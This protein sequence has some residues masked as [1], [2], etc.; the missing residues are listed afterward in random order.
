[1]QSTTPD[2][3]VTASQST[4]QRLAVSSAKNRLASSRSSSLPSAKEE[5]LAPLQFPSGITDPAPAEE[6]EE[7]PWY[8]EP[9]TKM[10][11]GLE[12]LTKP[13]V[14][15]ND[16]FDKPWA[17][18]ML[19]AGQ[20]FV[21]GQQ[22]MEK[23]M[24]EKAPDESVW[25]TLRNAYENEDLDWWKKFM[26]ESTA[27]WWMV[28]P[29][30]LVTKAFSV[31]GKVL[32]KMPLA[33]QVLKAIVN[34]PMVKKLSTESLKSKAFNA[35][36]R[37][38]EVMTR[39]FRGYEASSPSDYNK[40]VT[41]LLTDISNRTVNKDVLQTLT[42]T[43]QK[44]TSGKHGAKILSHLDELLDEKTIGKEI[45]QILKAE[46]EV[47]ARGG[48]DNPLHDFQRVVEVIGG[49]ARNKYAK[50]AGVP[51]IEN[52]GLIG[53]AFK[54]WK[55][56]VL[57][58]PTYV[59]QN[60]VENFFRMMSES[61]EPYRFAGFETSMPLGKF[62]NP[63][64]KKMWVERTYKDLN[65]MMPEQFKQGAITAAAR[66]DGFD[67]A[68]QL[69]S[70]TQEELR[71]IAAAKVQYMNKP[72]VLKELTKRGD[73]YQKI[74]DNFPKD[75]SPF[76]KDIVNATATKSAM[77]GTLS[78][79]KE[80]PY[81][82][83]VHALT[84]KVTD[85]QDVF[86][87]GLY[88]L[89]YGTE[90]AEDIKI[91]RSF[92]KQDRSNRLAK[93]GTTPLLI[94]NHID[95]QATTMVWGNKYNSYIKAH[96]NVE[97][98]KLVHAVLD[99]DDVKGL[100]AAGWSRREINTARKEL[101]A[102]T[103][104]N[105]DLGIQWADSLGDPLGGSTRA[106][107]RSQVIP[108]QLKTKYTGLVRDNINYQGGK[109]INKVIAEL[110]K[111]SDAHFLSPDVRIQT[112][113]KTLIDKLGVGN[114]NIK[115][116]L[117]D[118]ADIE[119]RYA[120]NVDLVRADI[121]YAESAEEAE[122]WILRDAAYKAD[123]LEIEEQALAIGSYIAAQDVQFANS[124][125]Y[126]ARKAEYMATWERDLIAT[127]AKNEQMT[128]DV[129]WFS[130]K[131]AKSGRLESP[132]AQEA[133]RG[134]VEK[135]SVIGEPYRREFGILNDVPSTRRLWQAQAKARSSAVSETA[136][137]FGR[138]IGFTESFK[139][140]IK[141]QM[142][143][144]RAE[145]DVFHNN[146]IADQSALKHNFENI[147]TPEIRVW[148]LLQGEVQ[149]DEIM[150]RLRINPEE[151]EAYLVKLEGYK[152][153]SRGEGTLDI[154]MEPPIRAS[155]KKTQKVIAKA[156][157]KLNEQ[158][159]GNRS[160]RMMD[161]ENKE[162]ASLYATNAT[163]NAFGNYGNTTNLDDI[164]GN[165][166]PFW[167]FPSRSI[168]F[169][170]RTFAQKPY[171]LGNM[172][173]MIHNTKEDSDL[174][175]EAL[176][177]YM[178]FKHGDQYFYVNPMRPW[179]GYQLFGQEPLAGA[180]QPILGQVQQMFG[181]MGFGLHPGFT[182]GAEAL[183]K[184]T[185]SQGVH[186]TRGELQPL[187]PQE[188]WIQDLIGVTTSKWSPTPEQSMFAQTVDG[189]PDW[190]RRQQEKEVARFLNQ[191][192]DMAEVWPT[193]R[194][195]I[196]DAKNGDKAAQE[197]YN[198]QVKRLSAFGLL[199]AA[200]PIHNRRNAEEI[201]MYVDRDKLIHDIFTDN[202]FSE[203]QIEDRLKDA[204]R[205]GFS[206]MMYFNK[207]QRRAIYESHPEW[208]PWQGLTR[209]GISPQEREME[210]QTNEF[211]ETFDEARE[212]MAGQLK[213][214]DDAYMEGL[215]TGYDWRM[216]YQSIQA[217]NASI[218]Q[219]LVGDGEA[220]DAGGNSGQLPLARVTQARVDYFREKFMD[221]KP[222]IHP[223]DEALNYYYSLSPEMDSTTGMLDFDTYHVQ[224]EEFL[225]SLPSAFSDY[226]K[227]D[228]RRPRFDSVIEGQYRTDLQKISTY[229]SV[230][231][232]V[233]EEFPKLAQLEAALHSEQDP[234]E[235]LKLQQE[236]QKFER[237]ISDRR[238]TMRLQNAKLEALLYKWGYISTFVNPDTMEILDKK[239]I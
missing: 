114:E 229:L 162:A 79:T 19:L 41:D 200:L 30:G 172:Q 89:A 61:F 207:Q 227:E 66:L 195:L 87:E 166:F 124:A 135:I 106:F 34:N 204:K 174:V 56:G 113:K 116:Y 186:L 149:P 22:S 230:R 142:L 74:M 202:G 64:G 10:G 48:M 157:A 53:D 203:K 67:D 15:V 176:V 20:G 177:G 167:Y 188:R 7:V 59:S 131:Y 191:N 194:K 90:R 100:R 26:L 192:P 46:L 5:K 161:W 196:N 47:L 38:N 85:M 49:A 205:K 220:P 54:F 25:T 96:P 43:L 119:K 134:I 197:I 93:I 144:A 50:E 104:E 63:F 91:A 214:A 218:W 237:I 60:Y 219:I 133:W 107:N 82:R 117:D 164:M 128:S 198:Q 145:I 234:K 39:L 118:I 111:E 211:F 65:P 71:M 231:R 224:R 132:E 193:P 125:A 170:T 222:P 73:K 152:A 18:A 115:T 153:I 160:L 159:A 175:P 208:E 45:Q 225:S 36:S 69:F 23:A 13:F 44:E 185:M 216:R 163:Y 72:A 201:D 81:V 165:I 146:I 213:V 78:R 150:K 33:N 212:L 112:L 35:S 173:H 122:K 139:P 158:M 103:D 147:N 156:Q 123:Q 228:M 129:T 40:I 109:G 24:A 51:V 86:N 206:P 169:Y 94:S 16:T 136:D 70:Y 58:T 1:M 126:K 180:G 37:T 138:K 137:A 27:P 28:M 235:R 226:I 187:F 130:N 108:Q 190:E 32:G 148:R 101:A 120:E 29:T 181:M 84:D 80:M 127:R 8:K 154:L 77:G 171:L 99:D 155:Y 168:P 199:S 105:L 3:P 110:R 140:K 12:Q 97:M 31:T 239:L 179:M 184:I 232:D 217:S 178:P 62:H 11:E 221:T 75:F 102:M 52:T 14:W 151:L 57:A 223:E 210:N 236:V 68:S 17:G 21:P 182:W 76:N 209:V 2:Q 98:D 215:I 143:R 121:T 4:I 55:S 83:A 9:A 141:E 92:S 238:Q 183:N 189:L 6:P 95:A 42:R 88:K 233:K